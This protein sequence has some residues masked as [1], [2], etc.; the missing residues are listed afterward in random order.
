MKTLAKIALAA[1]ALTTAVTGTAAA[2]DYNDWSTMSAWGLEMVD[3]YGN[4][5]YVDPYA[6]DSQ[7]DI[8]GNV[9]SDYSGQMDPSLGMYDLTPAWSDNSYGYGGTTESFSY[10]DSNPYAGATS[11]HDKFLESIWE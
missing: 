9:Y 1:L 2:Q 11:S 10:L 4:T 8:Y 7:V 5:H 3:E 6:Y